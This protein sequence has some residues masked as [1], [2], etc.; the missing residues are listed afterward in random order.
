MDQQLA[1]LEQSSLPTVATRV[2][3]VMVKGSFFPVE[4]T[5]SQPVILWPAVDV[6]IDSLV[7]DLGSCCRISV[8]TEVP[9]VRT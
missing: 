7:D 2:L 1:V 4:L 6:G 9:P 8:H 3:T 5:V